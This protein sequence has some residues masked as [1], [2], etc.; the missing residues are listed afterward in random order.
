MKSII[1]KVFEP[2]H[3]TLVEGDKSVAT[4][5]LALP[6]D[7]ISL[8]GSPKIG[9]VVMEA[10]AKICSRWMGG[11]NHQ[12]TYMGNDADVKDA[13]SKIIAAKMVNARV[14]CASPLITF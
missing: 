7:H 11:G 14:S 12:F 3:V 5:L 4:E 9:K 2:R 8:R 10:A 1:E 6:F 13:A